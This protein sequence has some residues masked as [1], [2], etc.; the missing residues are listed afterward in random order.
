M[1]TV[2]IQ[3]GN[4]DDK[5]KQSEWAS[6]VRTMCSEILNHC[7]VIHFFGAPANWEQWQNAAWVVACE[8]TKL[9]G[10]Q[11]AVSDVR[12]MFKQDSAAWTA[13]ETLFV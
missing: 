13:G 9:P 5:L 7:R 4:T 3:I 1:K 8:E 10:L 2:T 6:Y 12:A 11:A